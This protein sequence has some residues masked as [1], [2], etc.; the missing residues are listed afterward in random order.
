MEE[1]ISFIEDNYL[2]FLLI[3]LVLIFALIGYIVD[4]KKKEKGIVEQPKKIEKKKPEESIVTEDLKESLT[5]VSFDDVMKNNK[6]EKKKE[7]KSEEVLE[8]KDVRPVTDE[9]K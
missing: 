2:I 1:F 5:G 3:S 7:E 6:E 9:A 8:V 4:A